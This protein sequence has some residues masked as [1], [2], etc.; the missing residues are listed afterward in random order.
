MPANLPVIIAVAAV[1]VALF[2]VTLLYARNYVKV[3][4][5]MVAVF[6]GRGRPKIVR[7]G[8]RFR[9]PV[10]ERVDFMSLEPFNI[11]VSVGNAI[12]SNGV[13]IAVDVV[14]LIRFGSTASG[15]SRR[16]LSAS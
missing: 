2:L 10:L 8:A 4:P 12:S 3:P 15:P 9:V 11:Q 7:G 5:N 1:V 6:T 16:I 14:A 13:G